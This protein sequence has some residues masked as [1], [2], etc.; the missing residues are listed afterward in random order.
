PQSKFELIGVNENDLV[1][2]AQEAPPRFETA[3]D[4]HLF[5]E[6]MTHHTHFPEDKWIHPYR[7]NGE[8]RAVVN[9]RYEDAQ[10]ELGYF[11]HAATKLVPVQRDSVSSDDQ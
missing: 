2:M 10:Y 11:V 3:E 6:C 1:R 8:G 9:K 5:I 7:I 4:G